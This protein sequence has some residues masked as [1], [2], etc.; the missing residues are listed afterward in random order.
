MPTQEK[1]Q[2]IKPTFYLTTPIYYVNARPHLGHTYTTV[3]ADAVARWKRMRGYDVLFLTGTDEHGQKI[4]RSAAKAG[5]TPQEFA[6]EVSGEFRGLWD[7]MGLTY[8]D[9]IRTTEPRHKRGVQHL[10]S[11]LQKRGF[12]YKGTYSGQYCVWDELYVEGPPGTPCPDCGRITETVSEENYFF[13]LSA[14]ERKLLEY[15]EQHPDFIRPE[16]RRNEVVAFVQG[17]LRDLSISRTSFNWGIPVP[18]DEKHVIYVWMDALANYITALGYGSDDCANFNKYW[19]ADVHLI[20]K[21]ISRFHCVYWP[22]FLMAAEL[23]LPK[24]V[25]A[26]GW[27]LFEQSKMSKSRGN[28]VRAETVLDVLGADAL[29]Y[30]LLREVTFGQDGSFSFDALVQRYNADLANGYGNLVSRTLAMIEKYFDGVVPDGVAGDSGIRPILNQQTEQ[31]DQRLE[32]FD[33]SRAL[34]NAWSAIAAVDSYITAQAPW[35]V[36]AKDDAESRAKLAGILYTAA[37]A[38]RIIT[39]LVYP[40]IPE[41][42]TKVWQQLGLGDITKADLKDLKWGDLPPGTRLGELG[43]VF[44]RAEKEAIERMQK[45]EEDRVAAATEEAQSAAADQETVANSKIS[46]LAEQPPPPHLPEPFSATGLS[47]EQEADAVAQQAAANRQVSAVSAVS[48][49]LPPPQPLVEPV[50]P[51]VPP[52]PKIGV[53][54]FAKVDLRVAIIR[55]AERVPKADRLLR[56]EVDLGYE[57]RQIVAGIAEAYAPESLIGRKVVIV[58]NLAPRKLRG[59]ESNGMIVAASIGDKGTPVLAGFLEDVEIGARLK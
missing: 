2:D 26:H 48:D 33:F 52:E 3:A 16:A 54:D 40:V 56:L 4:E 36:A 7:R 58:A 46:G 9:Y 23:P 25:V 30:F 45:M 57:Q 15:Y 31:F 12:I 19:P 8:D 6:A 44:P 28:I 5:K 14:F 10:F 39:A 24:S 50:T 27:L 1:K 53:E 35:K 17:G 59:L 51:A 55:V 37:E 21:E 42:A 32:Q 41:A 13:K 11:E 20:G 34:E 29:R 38:I 22:A 47:P 49:P 43:P 18:G